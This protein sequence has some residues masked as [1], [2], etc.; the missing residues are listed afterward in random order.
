MSLEQQKE[1][2]HE[3]SDLALKR[4]KELGAEAFVNSNVSTQYATRFSNSEILQ[5]YVDFSRQFQLTVV[6]NGKQK[7]ASVTNDLSKESILNLVKFVT[8]AAKIVPPD[9][10]YPG[11]LKEIQDYPKLKLNDPQARSLE[12]DDIVDKIKGAIIAGE[13]V[14][15]SVAGVSGNFLLSDG[16]RLFSSTSDVE[17]VYPGTTMRSNLNIQAQKN[18]EE[19]RSNS[20]FG[21][22]FFSKLDM[23]KES[24][25]VAERAVKGLGAVSI[26]P[27]EYE[28]LLDHQA[29]ATVLRM[30]A[31]A[32]SSMQ[33]INRRSFLMDK[34][35]QQVFDK[36]Y[37]ITNEPHNVELLSARPLD[38]EGLATQSFPVFENGVLKNYSYSRLHAAKIGAQPKGCALSFMGRTIGI[39][40]AMAMKP[41]IKSKENLISEMDDGLLITNLHYTNYVNPPVGSITGMSKDGLFIIKNGE[42][43]GSAKNMR[44]TDELP[45][46]LADIDVG[47]ELRQPVSGMGIGGLVAPIRAKTFR[48][49]SK[50]EH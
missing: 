19:S 42:I 24:T 37:T 13:A 47:K 7:S 41:G 11:I 21:T 28:V 43:V 33:L 4:V 12:P 34:I 35:G 17:V 3:L 29:V 20:N 32:T 8:K 1:L 44:F 26:E 23:E 15:K 16:Y 31:F 30:T 40:F 10:M 39:P 38:D 46:F 18:C 50:T 45:R 36:D 2:L 49:T 22:R 27:G 25:E 48:F 9:P 5:N 14:D 6:Y